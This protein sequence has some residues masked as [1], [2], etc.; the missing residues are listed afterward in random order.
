MISVVGSFSHNQEC[1]SGNL[2]ILGKN[3]EE[4]SQKFQKKLVDLAKIKT[5]TKGMR[6]RDL[7]GNG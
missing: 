6:M 2:N 5:Y 4:K 7:V 3:K 1:I